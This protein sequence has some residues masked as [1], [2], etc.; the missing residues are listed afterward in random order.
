MSVMRMNLHTRTV[1][2]ALLSC[3]FVLPACAG[4][5]DDGRGE[6]SRQ[7]NIGAVTG[8]AVG[9]AAAGPIGAVIGMAAG[10][11]IG[12]HYHRQQQTAAAVTAQLGQ[13]EAERERLAHSVTQLDASLVKVQA[14][15]TQLGETLQQTNQIGLDVGFRTDDDAVPVHTMS[16]L[17]KIGALAAAMPQSVVRIVGYADP[18]G[19]EEYNDA[20]SLRRAQGVAA[21]LSSAGVPEGRIIVEARGKSE[22]QSAAGDLDG[23]AFDRRVT[24]R[25]EQPGA[26]EVASRD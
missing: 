9:A 26:A 5:A 1:G 18:R 19:S 6:P 15:D 14:R 20:L 11:V 10:V 8:L 16:P 13:S 12:D 21:V 22:S 24:V 25:L 7:S 23:Y 4:A 3:G 2:V 17:L